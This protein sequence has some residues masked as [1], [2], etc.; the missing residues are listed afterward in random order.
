MYILYLYNIDIVYLY[1]QMKRRAHAVAWH[2][3]QRCAAQLT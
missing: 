2:K 3:R 1:A